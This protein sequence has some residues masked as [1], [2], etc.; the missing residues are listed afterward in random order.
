MTDCFVMAAPEVET[1]DAFRLDVTDAP[2]R[3]E[4]GFYAVEITSAT[5]GL[6]KKNKP[7]LTI[8]MDAVNGE[9]RGVV[10]VWI[11]EWCPELYINLVKMT[12]ATLKEGIKSVPALV[13]VTGFAYVDDDEFDGNPSSKVK[14]LLTLADMERY[15]YAIPV[16]EG[17]FAD[18]A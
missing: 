14:N 7:M 5:S 18:A 8:R 16:G 15:H 6:S 12:G 3:L 13:G 10:S 1:A 11:G 9:T 2:S 17:D 4:K